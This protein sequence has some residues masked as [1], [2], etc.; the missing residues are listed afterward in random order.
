MSTGMME[1]LAVGIYEEGARSIKEALAEAQ[2]L[3]QIMMS[4]SSK[5]DPGLYSVAIQHGAAALGKSGSQYSWTPRQSNYTG[6]VT[7]PSAILSV[8]VTLNDG[9][10]HVVPQE[11]FGIVDFPKKLLPILSDPQVVRVDVRGTT[12][13]YPSFILEPPAG[14]ARYQENPNVSGIWEMIVAGPRHASCSDLVSWLAGARPPAEPVIEPTMVAPPYEERVQ[15]FPQT[16]TPGETTVAGVAA[17]NVV[18]VVLG[19]GA[20]AAILYLLLRRR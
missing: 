1:W 12:P 20:G 6:A 5:F 13:G 9:S 11:R 10:V 8:L 15:P 17:S 19:I 16:S 4:Y 3:N 2:R 14:G 18:P 7:W